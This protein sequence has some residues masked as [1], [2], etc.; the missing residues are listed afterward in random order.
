[1]DPSPIVLPS[2]PSPARRAPLPFV[3][4]VVPVA[5]GIVLWLVSGSLYALCFAALGPL[6]IAASVLDG[7]RTR[8][9]DRR[10]D[11]AEADAAWQSAE[12]ELRTRQQAE[13]DAQWHRHPDAAGCLMQPPLRGTDAPDGSTALVVGRGAAPS[14]IRSTGGEG[15]RAREFQRRCGILERSPLRVPLGQGVCVR[16]PAPQSAAVARALVVQLCLRFS[17]AQ[18]VLVGDRLQEHGLTTLPHARSA[19]R[20]GYRLGLLAPGDARIA[21]DAAVWVVPPGS[22][23]PEGLTTV[24]DVTELRCATVRTPS[25]SQEVAL[26]AFSVDQIMQIGRDSGDD[27][28][29]PDDVPASVALQELA[30]PS[31][32]P[33][34]PAAVG[35]S[36]Q[37][38]V[39]LDIVADGPHAIVTGT[40]G[41]GKSELLVTW[42]T[43]MAQAHGPDRVSF[44]LADFKGGTAFEPLRALR[45]V[46]AV[47]TDLDQDGARRGV[48]SLTAEIRRR[49]S[50]LAGAGARD[51][52]EIAIPR[53]VIVI[54]EFAALL[55]EHPDL[56]QVFTDVAARGRALGMHLILGTQRASG[57]VRDALAANCPLRFSLRV[58][59]AADSRLVIGTAEAAE[60]PGGAESRGLGFVR[61]PQDLEPQIVRVARTAEADV[62]RVSSE[63]ASARRPPSPWQPALPALLPLD[64]VRAGTATPSDLLVLGRA[65]VPAQQSQPV[66]VLRPGVDRGLAILGASGAGRTS[67]L[68]MLAAQDP[69]AIWMPDDLEA[70][71]DA[72]SSWSEG[73]AR[74]P[75]LVLCDDID[76]RTAELPPEYAQE[77][78]RRVEA[79]VRSGRETTFVITATRSAG[80]IG[81]LLESMPRRALLRMSSRVEH[82]AAG[83]E[84]AGFLADRPA[85]RARIG[86]REVQFAWVEDI[87]SAL[88]PPPVPRW[89]PGQAASGIVSPAASQVVAR[90]RTEYPEREVMMVQPGGRTERSGALLVADAETWQRHPAEWRR[91]RAEGEVLFRAEN[92]VDLRQL[93]GVRDLPPYARAHA[94]RAWSMRAEGPV[95]RVIVPAFAPMAGQRV[96]QQAAHLTR[97]QRRADRSG[98]GSGS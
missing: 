70:A 50:L 56:G 11:E 23:V 67:A 37:G 88:S 85:G 5:T 59:D 66:E 91:V 81:R 52:S 16:G 14:G 62:N 79:L 24:I 43:A 32:E 10:R 69:Q 92:P 63:W 73:H 83:G 31:G 9:R 22:D 17:P 36:G 38:D 6:M 68:R 57:V 18:L 21:V 48:T 77:W 28:E 47:I 25:G 94:G 87:D 40:T 96:G 53:L 4:A 90:L 74:L 8:R 89:S 45:Q 75:R 27:A 41:T 72:V 97:R 44:V 80:G 86:E 26:E 84:S 30:Q 55:Q 33:G 71:W 65:D 34:L 60:L 29:E 49:E 46:A 51:V 98:G 58:A 13:H 19:R 78:L 76:R 12:N 93:T 54:D 61:R 95:R 2:A 39:V 7:A 20:G 3:A 1:M 42:V 35:R 64:E 15:E 82:L